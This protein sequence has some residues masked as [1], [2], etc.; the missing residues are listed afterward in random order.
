MYLTKKKIN[1]K[2]YYYARESIR[3]GKKVISKNIA[4]LGADKKEAER[5]M[6]EIINN[7]DDK[8][9]LK[10]INAEKIM[11]K[12]EK[13]VE[14]KVADKKLTID[15][16]ATF[17]KRKGFVFKSSEIY[18]GM[19]GFWDYA[20]LGAELFNNIK[21]DFWKFFVHDKENM[22]GIDASIISHPRTW[23][24]S[25]HI[26]S[27]KDV[28]VVCKKCKKST[29]IDKSEVGKAKCEC[30]GEYEVLGE[31]SLMFKTS[32]GALNPMDAY[33]RGETAQGMF[34]D[35][36]QIYDTSRQ[37]LPFGIVQVGKCFRNEIA[38]RD[39]L[40]RDREFTIGEFEFFIH[41]EDDDCKLDDEHLN[42]K[43][44]LLDAEEQE[45]GGDKLK[46]TTIAR[47]I[48]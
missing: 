42:L 19:S 18:G 44:R 25:G 29:K 47:M 3:K 12:E 43:L 15:E 24:A 13:K 21:A 17:C 9:V 46:E 37:K 48:K 35:F 4:Y 33:L 16:L 28:A 6:K 2:E 11:V 23:E 41:P 45:K 26:G 31:F 38:P 36:K 5:K 20:P 27:F 30:N 39:F 40:F 7:R 10:P 22:T 14:Q 1:G 32:V 34:L 8:K